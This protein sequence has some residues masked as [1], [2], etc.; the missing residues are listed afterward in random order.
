MQE[1][2]MNEMIIVMKNRI[3]L[4]VIVCVFVVPFLRATDGCDQLISPH[5]FKSKQKAY[6]IEKAELTSKEADS[7]FPVYFKLQDQ[8]KELNDQI[9][10]LIRQG[11]NDRVTE[12]QYQEIVEKV[13]ELRVAQNDLDKIYYG[14]FKKI[15]TYRKIYLVQK[16][17][18]HFQREL[19][20][21]MHKQ[22]GEQ[23]DKKL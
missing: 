19:L 10:Q 2:D 11:K 9:A 4:L 17:E 20:K 7:F 5:E 22:K 14:K 21:N 8:K 3:I 23:N 12:A 13:Q 6:I 1:L 18:M 15:L 16:A